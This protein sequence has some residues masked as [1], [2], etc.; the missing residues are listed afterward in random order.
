MVIHM[1]SHRSR[2]AA[3]RVRLPTFEMGK[4]LVDIADR[5]Q[6]YDVPDSR[7]APLSIPT[8]SS[9]IPPEQDTPDLASS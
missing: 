5:D 3:S 2:K 6:L 1:R 7:Q 4:A 9:T 8:S